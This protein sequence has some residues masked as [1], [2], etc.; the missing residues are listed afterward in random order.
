M[1]EVSETGYAGE[2]LDDSS[3]NYDIRPLW[4]EITYQDANHVVVNSKRMEVEA[5]YDLEELVEDLETLCEEGLLERTRAG[6]TPNYWVTEKGREYVENQELEDT[7]L[8]SGSEPESSG[9]L[10]D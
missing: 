9:L 8:I 7:H 4:T 3:L 2:V 5:N 6:S 10:A 1:E